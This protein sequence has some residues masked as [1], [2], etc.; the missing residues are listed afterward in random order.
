[1]VIRK[2]PV[3]KLLVLLSLTTFSASAFAET[4]QEIEAR[5]RALNAE[6]YDLHQQLQQVENP[7]DAALGMPFEPLPLSLIHI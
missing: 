7:E 1:M 5:I 4:Q 6:L 2:L 3:T